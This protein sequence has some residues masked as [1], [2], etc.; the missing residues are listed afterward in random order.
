MNCSIMLGVV[1]LSVQAAGAAID[2]DTGRQLFVDDYLVDSTRGVVRHWNRPVKMDAPVVAPWNGAAPKVTD[3]SRI[4]PWRA[5]TDAEKAEATQTPVRLTA[6]TDG[7]LWWDPTKRK[8]RLWYQA[9]WLGDICYAESANGV[10]WEYPD[11][12]VVP[13]TN[14]IFEYDLIDSW[15]VCPDYAAENP[16]AAW[17]LHISAPGMWTTDT[18]YA[19]EDG[20]H[21]ENLGVAGMS[22]DRSTMYYDP[23]R[24]V[25]VFSL[26]DGRPKVGRSRCYFASK[27]FGGDACHWSWPKC[28]NQVESLAKYAPPEEW[29]VATNGVRRSLY[30]F[31][32][33]AYESLMLGVMEILYATP[34]D[35]ADC[36]K[37]GLPKQ[38]ALH[39]TFSRDGKTYEPRE[40]ADIAPEGWGSGKWDSGYLSCVGG[41]CAINDERLWF[42]YTGLRGDGERRRGHCRGWWDNGMYS[43]GAIG[44]ATLRRD[45]FAGMVADGMGEIVTKP[46]VFSGSRL[47]INAECRFGYVEA[48]VLD[49]AGNPIP[50]YTKEDCAAFWH[51][52]STKRELVFKGRDLSALAGREVRF[53]FLVRCGTLYSFWVSPTANGESRG[54]VAAGG[55]A[56][57]GLRDMPPP[58]VAKSR[59]FPADYVTEPDPVAHDVNSRAATLVSSMAVAPNGRLWATWYCGAS[60]AED[61]NNYVVLATSTDDGATWREV[62]IADPDGR[63]PER[64]FDP[65]VWVA[66]DGSLRWTWTDRIC[67]D[68][69][70]R[71]DNVY[72]D[73]LLMSTIPDA[74][75][76]PSE[77]PQPRTI[78]EGVMMCKP[79]VLKDGTWAFPVAHWGGRPWSS[80]LY[81]S[82]DG[83]KTFALRGGAKVPQEDTEFDEHMF[84]EK[85]NGD[86]VCYSRVKSGIR[87]AVS[88]DG[89][90]SWG[91]CVKSK[92]PHPSARAFVRK[93]KSGAWLLVKHGGLDEAKHRSHLTA[94][95]SDDEGATWKG[96]LLL[97]E[98]WGCSYPDGQEAAD[99]TI[100]ITYDWDRYNDREIYFC[101]F[102]EADVRAGK[103]VSG[104]VRLRQVISKGRGRPVIAP[105]Y[106]GAPR[107][108]HRWDLRKWQGGAVTLAAPGGRLW[109]TWCA[110]A[111]HDFDSH[112]AY[113]VLAASTDGGKKCKEVLVVDPDDFWPRRP[114]NAK[115]ALEDGRLVWSWTDKVSWNKDG[116]EQRWRLVLDAEREPSPD[117]SLKAELV[118]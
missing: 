84:V 66:P 107:A 88:K 82:T 1:A 72:P 7:G 24:G 65:E 35:N 113:A 42:Y 36:D 115:L 30:S 85:N 56:Y 111:K 19:S 60:P 59:T 29:L 9:D 90:F 97:E 102:T 110:D 73:I 8:F 49:A 83:G 57:H 15:C 98:R 63:G 80:C 112:D 118:K 117:D 6:A 69:A 62:F 21:F 43:N 78:A 91:P 4:S 92:L 61:Q 67:R 44:V 33:V 10:K 20:I 47:F 3:T 64:P 87:E 75:V 70:G 5:A 77:P 116:A 40:D 27:E 76:V 52:D 38:T 99:G 58:D 86:L 55:P 103:D 17:K 34:G 16:Y 28:T 108:D 45:G 23:F 22:C 79:T 50:G 11:L 100:Y 105:Q 96:G 94:Y 53:R 104:K 31:N 71:K 101:T 93:L 48:E 12:G 74:N 106:V 51:G 95:V 32:A 81:A 39:F 89:G 26:R 13:G 41:I 25:W 109:K 2:I 114:E 37:V 68:L 46:V 14:R 18:L 54:Y